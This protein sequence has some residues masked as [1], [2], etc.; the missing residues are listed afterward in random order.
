MSACCLCHAAIAHPRDEYGPVGAVVCRDCWYAHGSHEAIRRALNAPSDDE[1]TYLI[2]GEPWSVSKILGHLRASNVADALAR[3][4]LDQQ[5]KQDELA[6]LE[7]E[8]GDLEDMIQALL[9]EMKSARPAPPTEVRPL[10][11]E[12]GGQ[13]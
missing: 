2:A 6:E 8:I 7:E 9:E 13:L 4:E 11:T 12:A 5:E 3:A 1:P 10:L